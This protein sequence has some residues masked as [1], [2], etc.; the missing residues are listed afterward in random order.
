MNVF[1]K[2]NVTDKRSDGQTDNMKTVYPPTNTVCGGIN[3]FNFES[4][5][6]NVKKGKTYLLVL[7][8]F[9]GVHLHTYAITYTAISMAAKVQNTEQRL[10][11]SSLNIIQ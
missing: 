11:Y 10:L 3:I 2:Q 6:Y 5:T 8:L 9:L 4:I 7:K 1:A